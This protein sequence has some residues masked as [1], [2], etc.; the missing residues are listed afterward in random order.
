M[1]AIV[2]SLGFILL[3]VF[4][5]R[6][7]AEMEVQRMEQSGVT[8]Q[9][10]TSKGKT[11][12][13]SEP[14]QI[15]RHKQGGIVPGVANPQKEPGQE[16][17]VEEDP[18]RAFLNVIANGW[19][20]YNAKKYA[21]AADCFTTGSKAA[22]IVTR[23][24]ALFGLAFSLMRLGTPRKAIALFTELFNQGYRPQESG[25]ALLQLLIQVDRL[26]EARGLL[27]RMPAV[28]AKKWRYRL[29]LHRLRLLND[30]E[31][32]KALAAYG[33]SQLA[34][35]EL[36]TIGKGILWQRLDHREP[37]SA[38]YQRL[39]KALVALDPNDS[40][41]VDLV[42]W[43][44]YQQKDYVCSNRY[45]KQLLKRD[46]LNKEYLLGLGYGLK[47]IGR[48]LEAIAVIRKF[49]GKL[50]DKTRN[51]LVDLYFALGKDAYKAAR[52]S[53]A[54]KYLESAANVDP[55]RSDVQELLC[56]VKYHLGRPESLLDL[57]LAKYKQ[58]PQ[59]KT[60]RTYAEI[61]QAAGRERDRGLF[62]AELAKSDNPN[63]RRL[64]ADDYYSKGWPTRA[65]FIAGDGHT[66]Y[67]GCDKPQLDNTFSLRWH[68]GAKGSSLLNVMADTIEAQIPTPSGRQWNMQISSMHIYNGKVQENSII[69]SYYRRL[70]D[71]QVNARE[72]DS[73]IDVLQLD[74]VTS[75][76]GD[77]PW[78]FQLG[79]TP[80]GGPV[81]PQPTFFI[82]FLGEKWQLKLTQESVRESR[83]SWIGMEDPYSQ[84]NWGRVLRTGLQVQRRFSL[85]GPWWV[86]VESEYKYYW[87]E[88]VENNQHLAA[89]VSWG[90]SDRWL[91][92]TRAL[93][94]FAGAKGFERNSDFY[95]Y[96]HGGYFSPALMLIAGPFIHLTGESCTNFWWDGHLSAGYEY[97][98]TDNAPR[99]WHIDN[100][101]SDSSS[102]SI[103][104]AFQRYTGTGKSQLTVDARL[105]GLYHLGDSWFL[106]AEAAINNNSD[107]TEIQAAVTLRYRFGRGAAFCFTPQR[108][109][110]SFIPTK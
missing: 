59:T 87:G 47:A 104:D 25:A 107:F 11:Q 98:R 18:D 5:S 44:C 93:G 92:L 73:S 57:L 97:Y 76:E 103:N 54:Q 94:L 62:M 6:S 51:L 69:G 55:G 24:N 102:L 110:D 85:D 30:Q 90:K 60:A 35:H 108:R 74:M 96:G 78:G 42:A 32:M 71:A 81:A 3:I 1:R 12:T 88:N 14:I 48:P 22:G 106:G 21:K 101:A 43:S 15:D 79:T 56:W 86:S 46:P 100:E 9:Q 70:L 29:L 53:S 75:Q 31:L 52:F 38:I 50:N 64:A 82:D 23:Q 7:S 34:G 61:L 83:L 4:A 39:A 13:W 72:I 41:A 77:S 109:E 99:Y 36:I 66:C 58:Q 16:S 17:A 45:F 27:K 20:Y 91:G 28:V 8:V 33:Q 89:S 105:R 37:G 80:I 67:A 84:K 68:K 26:Q 19:S 2:L 49:P 63:L 95:T 65:A 10:R 40:K